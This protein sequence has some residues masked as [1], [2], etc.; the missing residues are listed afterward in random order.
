GRC[1]RCRH[2]RRG[3]SL[4]LRRRSPREDQRS[5]GNGDD[6]THQRKVTAAAANNAGSDQAQSPR[7]ETAA[8]PATQPVK[9]PTTRL[10]VFFHRSLGP[11]ISG[12]FP[13]NPSSSDSTLLVTFPVI[14]AVEGAPGTARRN[15]A[16][17]QAI[18]ETAIMATKMAMRPCGLSAGS[19]MTLNV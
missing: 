15:K 9:K 3:R 17:W 11:S 10:S 4:R 14:T 1:F 5:E 7:K 16:N 8:A 6:P 12:L 13:S 2:R 18:A 19:F